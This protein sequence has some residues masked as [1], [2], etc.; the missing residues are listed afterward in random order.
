MGLS[1]TRWIEDEFPKTWYGKFLASGQSIGMAASVAI[2]VSGGMSS[3]TLL[4]FLA[5]PLQ[6]TLG[7]DIL[8]A[9]VLMVTMPALLGVATT[10]ATGLVHIGATAI[11][12]IHD[13]LIEAETGPS[14]EHSSKTPDQIPRISSREDILKGYPV[15]HNVGKTTIY[16]RDP[17]RAQPQDFERDL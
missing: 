8:T 13:R 12:R 17:D 9:E 5:E 15:D 3:G 11:N 7:V 10:T 14:K 1:A 2:F 16:T 6:H 4:Q